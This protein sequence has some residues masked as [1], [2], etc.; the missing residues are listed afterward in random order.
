MGQL[1]SAPVVLPDDVSVEQRLAGLGLELPGAP[2]PLGSY[3]RG[4]VLRDV[5]YLSGQLPLRDGRLAFAGRVGRDLTEAQAREAAQLAALN[6]LAQIRALL[7]SFTGLERLV[8]VDGYV[9]GADGWFDAPRVLD[10]A[11]ALFLDALGERGRHARTAFVVPRLPL[12]APVELVVTFGVR[13]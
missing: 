10:G 3:E 6:A 9:A 13:A 4:V 2:A 12:D 1:T 7:G 5:G 8:R 11:S